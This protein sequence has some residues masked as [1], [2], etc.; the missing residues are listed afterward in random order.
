MQRGGRVSSESESASLG[1]AREH[2]AE[3]HSLQGQH[4]VRA[5]HLA[6]SESTRALEME[7][8]TTH[9]HGPVPQRVLHVAQVVDPGRVHDLPDGVARRRLEAAKPVGREDRL[10]ELGR[11]VLVAAK[12]L[13]ARGAGRGGAG[14]GNVES[15][16]GREQRRG[17][18]GR[19]HLDEMAVAPEKPWRRCCA[20]RVALASYDPVWWYMS[21]EM[22][23]W[24]PNVLRA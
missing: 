8:E 11:L 22:P 17:G 21:L 2:V 14:R 10:F 18:R 4:T 12:V 16:A 6:S 3:L 19:A 20:S 9:A 24:L 1:V 23:F 15:A 13:A 5:P 7:I